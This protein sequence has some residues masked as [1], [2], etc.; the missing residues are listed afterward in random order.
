MSHF[1]SCNCS[2]VEAC[3]NAVPLCRD[4]ILANSVVIA[5]ESYRTNAV[6]KYYAGE[7]Y[8]FAGIFIKIFFNHFLEDND[9][10]FWS[11]YI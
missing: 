3:Y 2:D 4:G 6:Y 9:E 1:R 7:T 8:Y 10:D 5:A 11:L